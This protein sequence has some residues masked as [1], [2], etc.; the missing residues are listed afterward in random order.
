MLNKL[1]EQIVEI[2]Y[3]IFQEPCYIEVECYC[4]NDVAAKLK[5]PHLAK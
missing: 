2:F 4:D 1:V 3:S 5:F